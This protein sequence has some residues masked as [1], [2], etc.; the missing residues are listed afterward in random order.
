[1]TKLAVSAFFTSLFMAEVI[2]G[3]EGQW[4]D[5]GQVIVKAQLLELNKTL[6][7]QV[8]YPG[9]FFEQTFR[10]STTFGHGIIKY[11]SKR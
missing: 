4:S 10:P 11:H 5:D 2:P 6:L 8:V 3:S 9:L 1:M 7:V